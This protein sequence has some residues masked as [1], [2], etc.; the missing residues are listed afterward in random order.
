MPWLESSCDHRAIRGLPGRAA[1]CCPRSR[2]LRT[3]RIAPLASATRARRP[4]SI[5][6]AYGARRQR[7]AAARATRAMRSQRGVRRGALRQ[8]QRA[9]ERDREE[10][11]RRL[12]GDWEGIGRGCQNHKGGASSTFCLKKWRLLHLLSQKVASPPPFV[13]KSGPPILILLLLSRVGVLQRPL[14]PTTVL[15]VQST[16]L[17][18]PPL[19]FPIEPA[20]GWPEVGHSVRGQDG[21]MISCMRTRRAVENERMAP[22]YLFSPTH[23]F[24]PYVAP[25]FSHISP[26]ILFFKVAHA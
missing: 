11:G 25:H 2:G 24:L 17:P 15:V 12:G 6:G 23:P 7:A 10:I 21:V 3:A 13:S 20:A 22:G 19:D 16:L 9:V 18:E 5:G 8:G 14:T 26:F 1:V 4:R